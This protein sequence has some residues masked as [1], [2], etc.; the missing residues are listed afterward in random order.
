MTVPSAVAAAA[1]QDM[2]PQ[3]WRRGT[4][5]AVLCGEPHRIQHQRKH[6]RQH[7]RGGRGHRRCL[8]P[9]PFWIGAARRQRSVGA[10]GTARTAGTAAIPATTDAAT[11]PI[12]TASQRPGRAGNCWATGSADAAAARGRGGLS[13]AVPAA[14]RSC[15][16]AAAAPLPWPACD[17]D[18]P[19]P[20][21]APDRCGA[22]DSAHICGLPRGC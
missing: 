5:V 11:R 4:A 16:G 22:C 18:Q 21:V 10:V 6:Q 19:A 3:R 20:A 12:V 8:L 9:A 7:C 13:S 14:A 17:A 2:A 1:T 15:F